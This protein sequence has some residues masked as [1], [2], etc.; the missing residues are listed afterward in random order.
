MVQGSADYESAGRHFRL[1]GASQLLLNPGEPYRLR[2]RETSESFTISFTRALADA[3]WVQL[4]GK[5]AL[6]EFPTVAGRSPAQ[7][8]A[9]LSGLYAEAHEEDPDGDLLVE[10]SYALLGEIAQLAFPRCE[11]QRATSY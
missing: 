5:T 6:P 9:Y 2:F 8:N 3:A 11:R 7:L 4:G 10:Q 1:A